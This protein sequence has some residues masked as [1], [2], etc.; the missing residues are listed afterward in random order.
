V[1]I[2][3]IV[4]KNTVKIKIPAKRG[5]FGCTEVGTRAVNPC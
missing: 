4:N 2:H 3:K 5:L 1:N